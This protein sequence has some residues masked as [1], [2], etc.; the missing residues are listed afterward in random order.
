MTMPLLLIFKTC[1]NSLRCLDFDNNFLPIINRNNAK[2]IEGIFLSNSKLNSNKTK[3]IFENIKKKHPS[4]IGVST[5]EWEQLIKEISNDNKTRTSNKAINAFANYLS[6]D[7]NIIRNIKSKNLNSVIDIVDHIKKTGNNSPISLA[8]KV[9]KWIYK[10][11]TNG[12]D[13]FPIYDSIVK[14][15]IPYYAKTNG[16]TLNNKLD[17]Y[18]YYSQIVKDISIKTKI[19]LHNIDRILWYFYKSNPIQ[20]EIAIALGKI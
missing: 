7:K 12:K 13:A 10:W 1:D 15:V 16:I 8:S 5:S 19:D 6:T 2:I 4:L 17:N 9:C 14:S 11:D 20:R 3:N 18:L